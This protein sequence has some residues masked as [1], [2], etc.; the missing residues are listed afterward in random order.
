MIGPLAYIGGKRRIAKQLVALI[1]NH[2]TYVE[3]FAGGAQVFFHKPHSKVE[4]LNDLDFEIVNF[5]R[6]CQRHPQEL[7]RVLR[8]QPASRRVFD[9]SLA[10]SPDLLTDVERAA[11]FFYLQQNAWSG[12]RNRQNFHYT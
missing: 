1:P 5:L 9:Q 8:W 7:S 6:I 3:P 11:R 10:Q 2:I 12:K 4:V